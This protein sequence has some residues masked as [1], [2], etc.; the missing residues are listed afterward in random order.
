M[1]V[2]SGARE[3]ARAVWPL[4]VEDP[5]QAPAGT[6]VRSQEAFV[7]S[8]REAARPTLSYRARGSAWLPK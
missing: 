7:V 3:D 8:G 6:S 2:W 4:C 1:Q 5:R